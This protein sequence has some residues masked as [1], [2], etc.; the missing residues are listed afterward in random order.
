MTSPI[1]PDLSEAP[2]Q[3]PRR[4]NETLAHFR[5]RPGRPVR[6]LAGLLGRT[7]SFVTTRI[8]STRTIYATVAILAMA[9][10][11]TA[12]LIA[13]N[14][15][16]GALAKAR[17]D[18]RR[19]AT[20]L[21]AQTE[22]LLQSVDIVIDG[23]ARDAGLDKVSTPEQF[24]AVIST[25]AWHDAFVSR[26][27][28]LPQAAWLSA[29]DAN[30]K[31]VN[32]SLAWPPPSF[33][34]A[35]RPYF[36]AMRRDGAPGLGISEP[37]VSRADGSRMVLVMRRIAAPN[38]R[39]LGLLTATLQLGYFDSF[40]AALGLPPGMRIALV[41]RDGLILTSFPTF[42]TLQ[43]PV[44]PPGSEWHRIV[45]AGGGEYRGNGALDGEVRLVSAWPVTGFPVVIDVALDRTAMFADWWDKL[46][47][48]G[49]VVLFALTGLAVLLRVVLVQYPRAQDRP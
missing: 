11:L 8:G 32:A 41:R 48:I 38:G 25:A 5:S 39:F 45:A 15:H 2:H 49:F 43:A 19:L 44:L 33:D 6:A 34:V 23:I 1:C 13:A 47:G 30:G 36:L 27:A 40:Y 37:T 12:G 10:L 14:L 24:R 17:H 35:D 28:G 26:L 18:N 22:R 31:V 42:P 3:D 7:S 29:V 9:I 4:S 16:A 46:T 20:V 21:A